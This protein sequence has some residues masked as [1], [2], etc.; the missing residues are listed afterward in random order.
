MQLLR[1]TQ[2]NLQA[3]LDFILKKPK[4]QNNKPTQILKNWGMRSYDEMSGALHSIK[5]YGVNVSISADK[6]IM[7]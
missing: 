5:A 1:R 3:L 4:Q 6:S 2:K 7:A